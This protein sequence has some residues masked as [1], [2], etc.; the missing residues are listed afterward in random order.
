MRFEKYF[1]PTSIAECAA[2]LNE[3]G[4]SARMLAGGTDLVPCL[5]N[6]LLKISAVVG[7]QSIPEMAKFEET[8]EGLFIGSMITLRNV[9][10]SDKLTGGLKVIAEAAGHVSSMQIRNIATIGGN[11][12]N[13]SPCADSVQGLLLSDAVANIASANGNR[14]VPLTD[15]FVEPGKTVLQEG[16]ML[17][18]YSIP[19]AA[20]ITGAAYEKFSIRGDTDVSIVGA[21]CRLNLNCDGV[22]EDARVSLGSAA[23]IPIRVTG[24]EKMLIGQKMTEELAKEAA[25]LAK[26]SCSPI[27]DQRATASYRREMVN[28]WVRHVLLDA[29]KKAKA[30]LV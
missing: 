11:A 30:V 20:A 2:V 27:D 17:V 7:L 1:E 6:R 18:G 16:E 19:K 29:D 12:C 23:P 3:Y 26:K 5:K 22:I 8:A 4:F 25:S 13:A 9:S 14:T 24:V 21:G 15:F 28:V 10:K